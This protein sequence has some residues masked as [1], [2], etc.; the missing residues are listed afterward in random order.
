MRDLC[1]FVVSGILTFALVFNRKSYM[2]ETTYVTLK[3][4]AALLQVS[5]ET[6]RRAAKSGALRAVRV[7]TK[8]LYRITKNDLEEWIT[9][10]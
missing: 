4:A 6:I 10:K 3:A 9:K 7:G 2:Q 8:G 5:T 1:L